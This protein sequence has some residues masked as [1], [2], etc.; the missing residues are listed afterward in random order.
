MPPA[1]AKRSRPRKDDE[2]SDHRPVSDILKRLRGK[3]SPGGNNQKDPLPSALEL[4]DLVSELHK[5]GLQP[6]GLGRFIASLHKL[7]VAS[8]VD[9]KTLASF[10]GELDSLSDSGKISIDRT[11]REVQGLFEQRKNLLAEVSG[12]Q[13][14]KSALEV[15]LEQQERKD[16]G[17]KDLQARYSELKGQLECIGVLP[18]DL[19]RLGSMITS[20][21]EMGYDHS[22]LAKLL[23]DLK[24]VRERKDS[25]QIE[26]ER[27]LDSKKATQQRV[28][29]LDREIDE[30]AALLERTRDLEKFGLGAVDLS[31]LSN[32]IRMIAKTRGI[33]ESAA[34][35]RFFEDLQSYY[36]NDQELSGRI[37]T[38]EALLREKE[39]KFR[40]IET[41]LRNEKAVLENASELITSGLNEQW[42]LKLKQI[43]DSYG[44]DL[45][46]LAGELRE[47][48]GLSSRIEELTKTK[49]VLEEEEKILRQKVVAAEDQRLKTLSLINDIIVRGAKPGQVQERQEEASR[50]QGASE[51]FIDSA[52][53]AIEN[54]RSRL[55]ANSPARLVLEHALLALKLEPKRK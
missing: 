21:K 6:A 34:K 20:A 26:M 11:R 54:I 55:P 2:S 5:L 14:K 23:D 51:D 25:E 19:S 18:G 32:V 16:V 27:L 7:A 39:E 35:R 43:L 28:L 50:L 49:R 31:E 41:D 44:T 22:E 37:R 24:A 9:P 33:D 3:K 42:L 4:A 36:A 15:E 12:L 38:L 48:K 52:Q 8:G 40:M 29:A 1:G 47:R 17:Y 45:D 46:V 53:K 13:N 10:I 30:K